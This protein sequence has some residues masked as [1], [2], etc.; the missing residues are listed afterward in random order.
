MPPTLRLHNSLTRSI[1]PFEPIA[2]PDGPVTFYTCG[3]TVYDDAHIGNF[4][5][6]LAADL[7]RRTLELLG[8]RTTH[9][10]NIT[11]VGHM[12]EDDRADG[13]GED[14][15]ALAGR[16]LLEAKKAGTLP[17]GASVD[18]SDPL[19]IADFYASRFLE[20]ARLLGL[21]VAEESKD[22]PSLMPRPTRFVPQMIE[23]VERLV[24]NGCA[25]V[26]S[27]GAVY[28]DVQSFPEY[29]RLSGNSVEALRAGEGG[30][31]SAEH[32]SVKR[33][34]RSVV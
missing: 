2:G 8:H 15:M 28:F 16:R 14:K 1:E 9:V 26:A 22:D 29:G 20:D 18:P 33:D 24:A 21:R 10:M 31:V 27:D 6:F 17:A 5:A 7:L 34:R 23:L 11:D 25:Y 13:G 12:T 30:R 4:R 32:Q 3:P 19:A